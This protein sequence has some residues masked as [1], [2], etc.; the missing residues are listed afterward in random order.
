MPEL[1]RPDWGRTT[2][3]SRRFQHLCKTSAT[4]PN[5]ADV[6]DVFQVIAHATHN[7]WLDTTDEMLSAYFLG[8]TQDNVV[9]L[10]DEWREAKAILERFGVVVDWLL[11]EPQHFAEIICYWNECVVA[12]SVV[13]AEGE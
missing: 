13:E 3:H 10:V 1:V 5:M 11:D 9:W 7:F 12:R 6:P 2:I 4:H 8:W